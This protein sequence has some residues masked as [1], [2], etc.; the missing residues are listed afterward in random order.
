M[1]LVL[2]YQMLN[3]MKSNEIKKTHLLTND[4]NPTNDYHPRWTI[5]Q[6]SVKVDNG[7]QM[8][9]MITVNL[10]ESCK[11]SNCSDQCIKFLHTDPKW[12]RELQ[13]RC[14]RK[15]DLS[16]PYLRSWFVEKSYILL[17]ERYKSKMLMEHSGKKS[18]SLWYK[19]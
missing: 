12:I 7:T 10:L 16:Y 8:P 18:K 6:Q 14:L 4:V 1:K 11:K 2:A 13:Y 9:T 17:S 5:P 3:A 19:N 15:E